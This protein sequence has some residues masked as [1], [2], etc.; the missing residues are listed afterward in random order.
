MFH[1]FFA[2]WLGNRLRDDLMFM[3][4]FDLGRTTPGHF[5]YGIFHGISNFVGIHNNGSVLVTG[6][7]AHCLNE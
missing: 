1:H 7:P 5:I 2:D 4:V 6:G 3:I